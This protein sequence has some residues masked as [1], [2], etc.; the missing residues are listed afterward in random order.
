M[1]YLCFKSALGTAIAYRTRPVLSLLSRSMFLIALIS[2]WKTISGQSGSIDGASLEELAT[3]SFIGVF[4]LGS[5]RW[6]VMLRDINEQM[7]SGNIT[8]FLLWPMRY[9]LYLFATA[10]GNLA[11]EFI[12]VGLPAIGIFG[13]F[14]GLVPPANLFWGM[15]F[16]LF[17]PLSFLIMFL[18]SLIGG[19]VALR[20]EKAEPIEWF[21]RASIT[22]LSAAFVPLWFYPQT[23]RTIVAFLPFAWVGSYPSAVYLGKVSVEHVFWLGAGGLL[24]AGGLAIVA[25]ILWKAAVWKLVAAGE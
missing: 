20:L 9:P 18:L 11:F 16:A 17:V 1:Y 8:M 22:L 7:R 2:I 4:F 23:L 24:W 10:C 13:L 3:Y 15:L 12:V 19:T 25:S 14:Y 5:W 6:E 21:L